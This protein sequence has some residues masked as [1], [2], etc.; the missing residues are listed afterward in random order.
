MLWR[1]V[2]VFGQEEP[3]VI[4]QDD[5]DLVPMIKYVYAFQNFRNHSCYS[6]TSDSENSILFPSI[7]PKNYTTKKKEYFIGLSNLKQRWQAL[8]GLINN[9]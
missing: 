9:D 7:Y 8:N 3:N 2:N 5:F 1:N 6:L 4:S